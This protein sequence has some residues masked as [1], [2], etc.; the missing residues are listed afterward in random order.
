MVRL[1]GR[2]AP[3]AFAKTGDREFI[4]RAPLSLAGA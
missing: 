3:R 2:M 1:A 4:V